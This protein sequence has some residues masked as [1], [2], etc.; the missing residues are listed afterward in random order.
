MTTN[1]E[2]DRLFDHYPSE[3]EIKAGL[4]RGALARN[5]AFRDAFNGI[6]QA[7]RMLVHSQPYLTM[8]GREATC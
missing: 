4:E 1:F 3:A 2:T 6:G 7:F 8:T 5:Q